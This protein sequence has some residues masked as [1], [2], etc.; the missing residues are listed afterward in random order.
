MFRTGFNVRYTIQTTA[1]KGRG[2]YLDEPVPK[3]TTLWRHVKGLYSVYDES[4]LNELFAKL[5]RNEIIYELEH[6]FGV[7]ELPGYLIR[8]ED[9]G[10]LINHSSHPTAIMKGAQ[11]H[12]EPSLLASPKDLVQA[13]NA[14]LDDRFSVIATRALHKGEEITLDYS[15][16]LDDPDFYDALCVQYSLS[17]DWLDQ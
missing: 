4:L 14:L 7:P 17:W 8:I 16:G 6:V 13:E 10:E 11:L 9:G 3:G 12:A 2:I 1:E 15:V 5:S